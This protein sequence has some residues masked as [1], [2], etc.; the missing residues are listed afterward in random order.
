MPE[1]VFMKLGMFIMTAEPISTSHFINPSHQSMCLCILLTLQGN[2]AVNCI[3][4]FGTM[5]RLGKR[6][7]ATR[8]IRNNRIIVG[9]VIFYTVRILPKESL[10]VCLCIPLLLLGKNSVKTFP[11][12]RKIIGS[13]VFYVVRVVSKESTLL[14]LPVTSCLFTD[15]SYRNLKMTT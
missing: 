8:N 9:R 12:Q 2:G 13:A 10:W 11:R 5:Q 7:P 15:L 1:T 14:V 4:P 6:V 3:T